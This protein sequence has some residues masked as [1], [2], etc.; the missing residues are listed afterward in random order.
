MPQILS[1]SSYWS[2]ARVWVRAHKI[3]TIIIVLIILGAG[4]FAYA[5][6]TSTTGETRYVLGT[7]ASSTIISSVS[8]SGQ[9]SANDQL[10]IKPTVSGA[11]TSVNVKVGQ[12][13]NA[14]TLI[15]SIDDTDAQKA[16]RDAKA[17]LQSAQLSLQKL[18]EPADQLTLTQ[19][20][21]SVSNAS[22][23]LLTT[24]NNSIND[25]T[26]AFLDLPDIMTGLQDVVTGTETNKASQW[27][28]DYYKNSIDQLTPLGAQYRDD[29]YNSYIV[30]RQSYDASLADFKAA[31]LT[32]DDQATV[33]KLLNEAYTTTQALADALKSD[34]GLVQLYEDTL[35]QNG[36][37]PNSVADTQLTNMASY[38]SKLNTHLSALLNDTN[39]ITT[40]KQN[41]TVAQQSLQ[42]TQ[43]G[44]DSL[45]IQSAQLSVTKAQNALTDAENNLSD[46]YLRAPFDGTI[47][48]VNVKKYDQASGGTAIATLITND[49][50]AELSVNEVDA[51]KI[52]VGQ[53]ATLTFDA[54][55]GLSIA[56]TVASVNTLGT[57]SQGVVS[58]AVQIDFTTQDPRVKPGMTVNANIITDTAPDALAVPSSAVKTVNGQSVV[59][60]FTPPLADN[61][62]ITDVVTAQAPQNVPVTTGISD[63]TD[64]QIL[65]GLTLG[66]Q[67]VV[68]TTTGSQ[69]SAPSANRATGGGANGGFRGGGGIGG[70]RLGG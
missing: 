48:A 31:N 29:A 41:I 6:S 61:G 18:E 19:G 68:R 63:D 64:V 3:W 69:T 8:E 53:K 52:Q 14:G 67:I 24:Y 39:Q 40:N 20:Q 11:I 25:I 35:K 43:A 60:V 5:K 62:G 45:D 28:V 42:K 54:I 12:K 59:Q 23:S 9:V 66:Q 57:V 33:D 44:A 15:A 49:Q 58:Y 46:Y 37:T 2:P 38:A 36:Q 30:A 10:D 65:S 32:V 50:I 22:T 17:N 13:V 7:V 51:A 56:G 16:V 26:S 70:I 34:N 27:N 55:D 21:N 4:W 1:L 47:A